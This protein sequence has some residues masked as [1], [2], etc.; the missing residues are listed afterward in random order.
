M[1]YLYGIISLVTLIILLTDKSLES[2]ILNSYLFGNEFSKEKNKFI[3][4]INVM[5]SPITLF[6]IISIKYKE[7]QLPKIKLTYIM[8]YIKI[9]LV[10]LAIGYSLFWAGTNSVNYYNQ[11]VG[12]ESS[13]SKKMNERLVILDRIT[14]IIHQKIE[15][16]KIN[17]SSYYK[18][19]LA[20]T[21]ARTDN[22]IS[23]EIFMKWITE[24]NPN[25][26]YGE[27]SRFYAEVTGAISQHR[28]ELFIVE[29]ELQEYDRQYTLLHKSFPST[30]F[31]FYRKNSLGYIP[32]STSTN[33]ETNK[34]GIDN[35]IN[36]Q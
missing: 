29:K 32:I 36:I 25:A 1:L 3:T 20:I 4:F 18:N 10:I 21:V 5:L 2:T 12:I 30:F 8:K 14:R 31:L 27:V 34:T 28:D 7:N 11:S 22:N 16:A 26:N 23:A 17:D 33:K 9:V 35:N 15:V 24:N 19:L 6:Q 13:F